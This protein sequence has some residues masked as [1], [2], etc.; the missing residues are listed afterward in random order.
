MYPHKMIIG[1]NVCAEVFVPGSAMLGAGRHVIRLGLCLAG[2]VT[3]PLSRVWSGW[4]CVW[5]VQLLADHGV[6]LGDVIRL[7]LCLAG[8]VTEPLSRMCSGR[9]TA[10]ATSGGYSH[11]SEW[12][13]GSIPPKPKESRR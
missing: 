12:I 13:F 6:V 9:G 1:G 3:E 11:R 5:W 7:G 4:G 10:G 8:A 2:V